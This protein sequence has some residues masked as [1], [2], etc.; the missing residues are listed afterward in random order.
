MPAAVLSM[1]LPMLGLLTLRDGRDRKRIAWTVFAFVVIAHLVLRLL[2]HFTGVTAEGGENAFGTIV[3]AMEY[4]LMLL[5]GAFA[6]IYTH[7]EAVRSYPQLGTPI[8]FVRSIE[9]PPDD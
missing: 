9:L 1:I 2:H 5:G 4:L 7:D 8:L 3:R 6:L